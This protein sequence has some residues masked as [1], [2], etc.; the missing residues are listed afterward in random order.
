MVKKYILIL[1]I[2]LVLGCQ[3]SSDEN[4]IDITIENPAFNSE[5]NP[6]EDSSS[7]KRSFDR[8][9]MLKFIVNQIIIPSFNN[10]ETNLEELKTSFD[11]F[12]EALTEENFT[13]LR[14]KWLEAYKAWQ[15]VEM[16]NIGK[17]MEDYYLYKSNIYPVDT[18]RVNANI[19]SGTY[20]LENPNNYS[21]QGFPTIDYLIYGLDDDPSKV[22]NHLRN[23]SKK[24]DYLGVIIVTLFDN[25]KVI[26]QNWNAVKEEFVKSTENTA[27]S[28]LNMMVNDF[29]YYYEKG[30]RANK[31]G[32]PGGVFSSGALPDRVEG[33]YSEV[34]TKELALVA[35]TSIKNFFN[36][37]SFENNEVKGQCL[38]SYLDYIESEK[39]KLLS[40]EINTQLNIAERSINEL[41]TSLVNQINSDLTTLLRTYDD[42]QATVPLLKVD[43]LQVMNMNVDYADADG[44]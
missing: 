17:A 20:D 38:K 7:T 11:L 23:D 42:I 44:D 15:S 8:E 41:D 40:D 26:K 43:M 29:I 1:F 10:L 18:S 4:L 21:A 31:F 2:F 3:N 24:R 35:M 19:D 27:S 34:F 5:N 39:E 25:T 30:F 14:Y 33:Y 22:I 32:I 6:E 37:I 16:F 28:N 36:G 12:E 9:E 13:D